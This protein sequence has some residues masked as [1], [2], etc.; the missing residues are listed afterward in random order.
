MKGGLYINIGLLDRDKIIHWTFLLLGTIWELSA[1]FL[2]TVP[3]IQKNWTCFTS[4]GHSQFNIWVSFSLFAL[5]NFTTLIF[6]LP[7]S[8]SW[9][10]T[11]TLGEKEATD[12]TELGDDSLFI[13]KAAWAVLMYRASIQKIEIFSVF[14]RKFP[15]QNKDSMAKNHKDRFN[16][17]Q[18]RQ[19]HF[20]KIVNRV[21]AFSVENNY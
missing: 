19:F 5:N 13:A 3:T 15:L 4:T 6:Y 16:N 20:S 7:A 10:L 8:T 12:L 11:V 9:L 21:I 14:F 17:N 18:I 1:C 2:N